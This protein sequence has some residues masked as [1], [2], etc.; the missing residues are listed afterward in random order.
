[1]P[2]H[3]RN[4][5]GMNKLRHGRKAT[6]GALTSGTTEGVKMSKHGAL[7]LWLLL[8]VGHWHHWLANCHYQSVV[9]V[10]CC[11]SAVDV[12]GQLLW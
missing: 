7:T 6:R 12:V 2:G 8:L 3:V 1:M 4:C 9:I 10:S 5:K 11:W